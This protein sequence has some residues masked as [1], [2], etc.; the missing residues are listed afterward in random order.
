MKCTM[1]YARK[2]TNQR[3][4]SQKQFVVG[5]TDTDSSDD[6]GNKFSTARLLLITLTMKR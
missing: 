5:D 3:K 2:S 6:E 1:Q 4:I